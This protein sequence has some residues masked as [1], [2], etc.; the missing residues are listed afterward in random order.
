MLHIHNCK[1]INIMTENLKNRKTLPLKTV[2]SGSFSLMTRRCWDNKQTKVEHHQFIIVNWLCLD[3][4]WL[5]ILL[6]RNRDNLLLWK[7]V[8]FKTLTYENGEN[9]DD[10]G[11]QNHVDN[12]E[13]FQTDVTNR[14]I[15]Q[16]LSRKL[17]RFCIQQS[18]YGVWMHKAWDTLHTLT[19]I[20]L[21]INIILDD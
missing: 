13:Q 12:E 20:E 6:I 7:R 11:G 19:D 16:A 10:D 2:K 4:Q 14:T 15:L 18:S 21:N 8:N 1:N 9:E 3:N 5:N 17:T